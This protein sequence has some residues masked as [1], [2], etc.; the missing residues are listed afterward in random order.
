MRRLSLQLAGSCL[1][2][3]SALLL[4][5]PARAQ[6]NENVL[7]S[8]SGQP[9]AASPLN[10]LTAD[11]NGNLYGTAATG[12]TNNSGA[13]FELIPPT[14]GVGPWT[15]TVLYSFCP[16]AGCA[17]GSSPES[18][19]TLDSHGNLFGAA[20]AGGQGFGAIFELIRAPAG[21]CA[22]GSNT[23]KG[24]CETVIYSFCPNGGSSGCLDGGAPVGSLLIDSGGN[25][26]GT[27]DADGAGVSGVVYEL[28]PPVSGSGPWTESVLFSFNG[29]DGDH[30]ASGLAMDSAGNLY[31]LTSNGGLAA[32]GSVFELSPLPSGGSCPSGNNPGNGWCQSVLYNFCSVSG[33]SDGAFPYQVKLILDSTGNL[34]GTTA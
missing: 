28:K 29:A 12:G 10:S 31:G 24:W 8:F 30:S 1:A 4:A 27:T 15:E 13:V 16:A 20:G 26:Y 33:C 18:G 2:L 14:G 23:G 19:V 7:Y 25:M 5:G 21:G 32:N 17:D 6:Y 34:Y 9:D 11:S 22:S 3:I